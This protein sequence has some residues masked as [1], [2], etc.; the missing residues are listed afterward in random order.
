MMDFLWVM[1][2][3]SRLV[4][5]FFASTSRPMSLGLRA[6]RRHTASIIAFIIIILRTQQS[7]RDAGDV[8]VFEWTRLNSCVPNE[9]LG[10]L[11]IARKKART[12]IVL[13]SVC[14]YQRRSL[15]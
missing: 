8:T 3:D 15:L 12:L 13:W 10:V 7:E 6:S 4:D 9:L 14:V 11:K 5:L 2:S 1:C